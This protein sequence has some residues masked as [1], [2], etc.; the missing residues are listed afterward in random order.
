MPENKT[1]TFLTLGEAAAILRIE[2]RPLLLALKR[3][4]IPGGIKLPGQRYRIERDVF[5]AWIRETMTVLETA[6]DAG[7]VIR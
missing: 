4:R 7:E 1:P 2:Q 5:F 3:G 6:N